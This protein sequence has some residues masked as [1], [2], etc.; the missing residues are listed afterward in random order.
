MGAATWLSD[1]WNAYLDFDLGARLADRRAK[2]A[3]RKTAEER[4]AAE[5]AAGERA[6]G[7]RAMQ[8]RAADGRTAEEREPVGRC[9]C[10]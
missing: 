3:E 5:R 7:E 2:A 4:A 1:K 6:A 8:A 10:F 9:G